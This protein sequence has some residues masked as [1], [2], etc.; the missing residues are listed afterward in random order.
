MTCDKKHIRV[1]VDIRDLQISVSGARVFL[2]EVMKEFKRSNQNFTFF[3]LDSPRKI[4]KGKNRI[5][6]IWEQLHFFFWK[7]VRL[8]YKAY[9]LKC[10]IVFC[11]DFIVPYFQPS[12]QTV[13]VF[14]DAF[15][16]EYPEHYNTLWLKI[17]RPLAV[18]AAKKSPYIATLTEHS[19]EKIEKY[20]GIS[21]HKIIPVGVGAPD[22]VGDLNEANE[23]AK[24]NIPIKQFLLHVGTFEKRKN[25]P[26]LI[27]AFYII[28][29]QGYDLDL[30]LIGKA[31]PKPTLDDSEAI[32]SLIKQFELQDNVIFPGYISD[33]AVRSYYQ[34]ASAYVFPSINEGFGIPVLEAYYFNTPLLVANCS[35]LPEVA[36]DGALKFDPENEYDLARSII[37]VLT[38]MDLRNQMIKKGQAQLKKYSWVKTAQQLLGIFAEIKK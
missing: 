29:N 26:I 20:T 32:Y 28:R 7:Q 27:K 19:K 24:K 35:C 33:E 5:L 13:P 8:P 10:D 37:S 6:K 15:F 38:N 3:F 1:A 12:F 34:K 11:S 22:Q 17:F 16:W 9:R 30:V 31:S 23:I 4:Y 21:Q 25:L 14:Y 2:E 36:G 18:A